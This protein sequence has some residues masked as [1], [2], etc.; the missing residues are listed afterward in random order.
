MAVN[1][2]WLALALLAVGVCSAGA[3]YWDERKE[4]VGQEA[5]LAVG[6][7]VVLSSS[8]EV[9][10]ELLMS[11]KRREL[12]S[13]VSGD[14]PFPPA[15][16]FFEAK[17][18]IERSEVFRFIKAL[19]KGAALHGHDTS[20]ASLSYVVGNLTHRPD[21]YA[22]A[23]PGAEGAVPL[24]LTALLFSASTPT[25]DCTPGWQS[26]QQLRSRFGSDAIDQWFNAQL[27][28]VT[29]NPREKYT[30]VDV[31]W[32]YFNNVFGRING[33]LTYKPVFVEY[34]KRILEELRDDN[35]IYLELRGTLPKLYDLNGNTWEG[36][37]VLKIY[38]TATEEFMSG[39]QEHFFGAKFIYGPIRQVDNG[40]V[41]Q[42]IQTVLDL[43]AK[44]PEFLAGFDLVGQEDK[45]RPL[46]DFV[47][48]ILG[49]PPTLQF[50]FHA[51][52]T[53]WQGLTDQNLV[54]AVL[55]NT[56]RIGHGYALLK[57][58][59][60]MKTVKERGIAIE[61]NP[62]SNQ[63]LCLVD[64]L[65]NHPAA[66]LMA[67]DYPV[68]ISCDDPCFWNATALS[69]DFY[70]AFMGMASADADLRLLK[71]LAVN[72]ITYSSLA[73]EEKSKAFDLWN[74]KWNQFIDETIERQHPNAGISVS[75]V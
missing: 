19:P 24:T 69:Y 1:S 3:S 29:D 68:V 62:I 74:K 33:L 10:N 63:V 34:Y 7:S 36:S 70:E 21:L 32:D 14:A 37:E 73:A 4:F 55:L 28:L 22:C 6:S 51:G 30:S 17:G 53:K 44:Y 12:A 50:F 46:T 72:S 75:H 8:E 48:R 60:V 57:H 54:D 11:A 2:L 56:S 67:D 66:A 5:G 16:H 9:V 47:D 31:V 20:M 27:S 64:D 35:I 65:R 42:E 61:V 41:D 13:A 58:P 18:D 43:H 52:E 39:N 59:L 26:V 15:K 71:M 45:G 38:K 40:T 23:A 25:S 49:L